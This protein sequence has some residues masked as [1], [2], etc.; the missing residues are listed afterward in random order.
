[1]MVT[2]VCNSGKIGLGVIKS[3]S[4]NLQLWSVSSEIG[5]KCD[6][7]EVCLRSAWISD[8]L[9]ETQYTGQNPVA[10]MM[11]QFMRRVDWKSSQ[12]LSGK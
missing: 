2:N 10:F 1:M 3:F 4:P 11:S 6:A 12:R 5:S 8:W 9:Q 7:A